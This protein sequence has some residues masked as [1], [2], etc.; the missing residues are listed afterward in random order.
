MIVQNK[1]V[2]EPSK[3]LYLGFAD[4]C[5]K[6]WDIKGE[7]LTNDFGKMFDSGSIGSMALTADFQYLFIGQGSHIYNCGGELKQFNTKEGRVHKDYGKIHSNGI[8]SMVT[9]NDNEYLLMGSF[10]GT[11]KQL[12]IEQEKV[13]TDYGKIFKHNVLSIAKTNDDKY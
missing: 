12:S 5:L 3:F 7:D 2:L 8:C 6:K 11:M 1:N 9:T 13:T 4:G 10:G